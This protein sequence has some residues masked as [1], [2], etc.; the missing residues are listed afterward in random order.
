MSQDCRVH[1]LMTREP[2]DGNYLLSLVK[3]PAAGA[4]VSFEGTVRNHHDGRNVIALEYE[5]YEA[6][7][8]HQLDILA[9]EAAERWNLIGIAIAHRTG[10]IAIGDT[11]V[12]IAVSSCHRQEA[13]DACSQLIDRLKEVVP[14]WKKETTEEGSS[15][16]GESTPFKGS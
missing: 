8:V 2:I 16:V 14:I 9:R 11:A 10:P 7:A 4:V 3:D 5:A 13:F 6:M 12:V 1:I 15:W